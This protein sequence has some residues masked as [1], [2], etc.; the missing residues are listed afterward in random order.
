MATIT[1][2]TLE[3][4]AHK[5]VYDKINNRSYVGDPRRPGE[6]T[7]SRTFVYY[8]DPLHK[9]SSFQDFPYIVVEAP[10]IEFSEETRSADGKHKDI[11]WSQNIIVRTVKDGSSNRPTNSST[12]QGIVD[13]WEICDDIVALFNS[14]ARK[15]E[16]RVLLMREMNLTKEVSNDEIDLHE[17]SIYESQFRLEY[18]YRLKVS[19]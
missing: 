11:T 15:D 10:T 2:T 3:S 4:N 17:K 16:F 6:T 14:E 1:R 8:S 18:K 19:E 5:N 12:P 9:D 7:G 13:M